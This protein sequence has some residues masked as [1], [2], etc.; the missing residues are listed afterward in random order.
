MNQPA[1]P[2]QTVFDLFDAAATAV[3]AVDDRA[4]IRYMN[5]R[6]GDVFGFTA[7]ELL[8]QPIEVLVPA[9]DAVAHIAQRD[10]Y[11][12][13]P[14]PRAFDAHRD[15]KGRRKDGTEFAAEV[16]LTP[17][18][19]RSGHWVVV[20]VL[21][22]SLRQEAEARVRRESRSYLT[23]ARLNEAVAKADDETTLFRRTCNVAVVHGGFMGAWI[24]VGT[25]SDTVEVRASAGP[26]STGLAA[27]GAG[28]DAANLANERT[29]P[30]RQP[31]FTQPMFREAMA[32]GLPR[33]INDF[34][35]ATETHARQA[36][37]FGVE[38]LGVLPLKSRGRAVA[39]LCL[40]SD[41]AGIFDDSMC[42]LLISGAENISLA[43]DRFQGQADL[44]RALSH[45]TEL[46][47]RLVDAQE[48]ERARIAADVH[49]EP[50]QSLAAVD[51][52]LALLQRQL[53]DAAPHLVPEVVRIHEII[54]SVNDG[55]R[56]L[57]FELEPIEPSAHLTDLL[58]DAATHIFEFTPLVWKIENAPDPRELELSVA[59]RT[60]AVRMAKEAMV[61]VAKHAEAK[62][63]RIV[64]SL[65]D[66]G[67]TVE[68]AD[69][70]VG[71]PP[72][73]RSSPPGHRGIRG[74]LDRAEVSG[75]SL[76]VDSA[77]TGTTISIWLPRD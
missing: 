76:S 4:T 16:S 55:L 53:A 47:R 59:T 56:D 73:V 64:V 20:S 37:T 77:A 34:S 8:G 33:F 71:L 41:Q 70:G 5:A 29:G 27:A 63:V 43:L 75:G 30:D 38:A 54:T 9:A 2:P 31:D 17:L 11:L 7:E 69:D 23:L 10:D 13:A 62:T 25:G 60:Q 14:E 74:M 19:T 57:L 50:V 36:V 61:N 26:L 40:A 39:T 35:T 51:L 24:F 72:G 65:D 45:G 46:Q 49:D 67:V 52:R 28:E 58:E 21:D 6:A 22:I 12:G 44:G 1:H 42:T 48:H 18:D 3:V 15:L 68:V 66:D 32:S